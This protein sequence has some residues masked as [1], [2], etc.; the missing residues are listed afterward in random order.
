MRKYAD[1]TLMAVFNFSSE[2]ARAEFENGEWRDLKDAELSATVK[3]N[4]SFQR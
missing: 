2:Y 4:V 3:K 1:K